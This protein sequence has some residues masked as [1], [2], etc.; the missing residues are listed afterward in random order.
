MIQQF[1]G[2]L[3][4]WLINHVAAED[5]KSAIC[6]GKEGA[7]ESAKNSGPLLQGTQEVFKLMLDLD[8]ACDASAKC[9]ALTIRLPFH[10]PYGDFSGKIYY[11]F[12]KK[13]TLEM[14]KIMSG[15]EIGEIDDFVTSAM[16]RSPTSSRETL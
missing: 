14:V 16:G 11:S 13:T 6:Q 9:D 3:L 4:A 1:A 7:N 8:A 10:R 5:Q 15:M 2:K 12:P